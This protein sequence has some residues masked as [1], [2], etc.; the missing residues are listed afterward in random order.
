MA[1]YA[2]L[3]NI[4]N[5]ANDYSA[6]RDAAIANGDAQ[7]AATYKSYVEKLFTSLESK[8][9]DLSS[10]LDAARA[11]G[12][13]EAVAT[14]QLKKNA[15]ITTQNKIAERYYAKPADASSNTATDAVANE[16]SLAPGESIV[17][18]EQNTGTSVPKGAAP[19]N[20]QENK[21]IDPYNPNAWD[22]EGAPVP[23]TPNPAQQASL[24][25]SNTKTPNAEDGTPSTKSKPAPPSTNVDGPLENI[26]HEY[27]GYT[28][29]LTLH[30]LDS[31]AYSELLA[32]P[33][34]LKYTATL[35]SSAS[36]F[37]DTRSK[38]F[39][40]DFYFDDFKMKTIIGMN[41]QTRASNAVT[42]SFTIIEP[43]GMT[44]I[45]RLLDLSE[46]TLKIENYL[47]IPYVLQLDFFG[48]EDS[49]NPA[50]LTNLTKRI[51]IRL[52]TMKM[53]AGVKGT[54]YQIEAVPF[55]HQANFSTTQAVPVQVEIV[56][57][58]VGGF[59]N[60][61]SADTSTTA[62]VTAAKKQIQ[63]DSTRTASAQKEL[64]LSQELDTSAYQAPLPESQAVTPPSNNN[65]NIRTE[66]GKTETII[67][68][69]VQTAPSIKTKNG[70]AAAYNAWFKS[71]QD[72]GQGMAQAD[73]ISF[74]VQEGSDVG[75]S[76][77]P[78]LGAAKL[79]F[80]VDVKKTE[81]TP[82]NDKNASTRANDPKLS[83][84]T[85]S[86]PVNLM[87]SGTFAINAGT[88]IQSVVDTVIVNSDYIV[89]QLTNAE[90]KTA[91]SSDPNTIA[92]ALGAKQI[93]WYRIVPKVEISGFDNKRQT[94]AK[95]LTYY[96]RP[97][98]HYNMRDERAPISTLPPPV[99]QYDFLYTGKNKDVINFD[100]DFNALFFTA[101][102][103]NLK[104]KE[105]LATEKGSNII[106]DA[107]GKSSKK[108][109]Y[110][111][112][113]TQQEAV[114]NNTNNSTGGAIKDGD[115]QNAQSFKDSVY[116]QLGG[117][118]LHLKLQ[119]LGDPDFIKQDDIFYTP[120]SKGYTPG[121][122][123]VSTDTGSSLTM[124]AGAIYCR[125]TFKTPADIDTTTGGLSYYGKENSS[126]FSGLYR[127]LV[128]D[129]EFR[130]G[131]F[132]QTLE[133]VREQNQ[134][135]DQ[136]KVTDETR[137]KD[138]TKPVPGAN[139]VNNPKISGASIND[140]KNPIAIPPNPVVKENTPPG[141]TI[142]VKTAENPGS[143]YDE[144]NYWDKPG[145]TEKDLQ[146]ITESGPT[147]PIGD[148]SIVTGESIIGYTV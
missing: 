44:L 88:S 53:K 81:M 110:V 135:E 57:D 51:P 99:K 92:K 67:G 32:D 45:N 84:T 112:L 148:N 108:T 131:K 23:Y 101:I 59:F 6:K 34:N 47:V 134:I 126:A 18:T 124:D 33:K 15:V 107:K 143:L 75:L 1:N 2:E 68:G 72:S 49:G 120:E 141:P 71:L 37:Q 115:K 130:Q 39:K 125:V 27:P 55:G 147:V 109:G 7:A 116:S 85:P 10:Q 118:M 25:T 77:V 102:Q 17:T 61:Q 145:P 93:Y 91:S 114:I 11:N 9:T 86:S 12:D 58:T 80:K 38:F 137:L 22:S 19:L 42:L 139:L 79:N 89:N 41:A 30:A 73:Q 69:V 96:I 87:E 97:Y 31:N 36:R 128:V 127:I 142:S 28:Y 14:L 82:P 76:G 3:D 43:Y 121:K 54:E 52:L 105:V 4:E 119:I 48:Y 24:K 140:V 123:R 100:M 16:R 64:S 63:D 78:A 50:I 129:S 144:P 106:E 90:S 21:N 35:I 122:P 94:W 95:K 103:V 138:P 56:A 83:A 26:L 13:T 46:Q 20:A 62:S 136:H 98:I 133:L 29:G 40:D 60:Q 111:V 5:L 66:G 104:P 146:G 117:D 70:F 113:P 65:Y 132:T 8:L 74:V